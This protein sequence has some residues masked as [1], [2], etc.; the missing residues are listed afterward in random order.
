MV[1]FLLGRVR[2]R[3]PEL[4]GQASADRW[5]NVLIRKGNTELGPLVCAHIDTAHHWT[6]I[7][8]VQHDGPLV[9]FD[10]DGNR[11]GIGADDK[12]GVF[13]C[14]ALLERFENIAVALF[15]QEEIGYIGAQNAVADFFENIGYALEFDCPA[16]GLVSYSA[17]GQRLFQNDGGFIE[18]A[19]P[20]LTRFGFTSFQHHP[21]TDVT[22]LRKRFGFSCLN[23]S[24]GY[25][26]WHSDTE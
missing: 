20:V 17:G 5:N 22:G 14:L 23:V 12:C 7:E 19:L 11:S 3:G 26:G 6:E 15:A 4:C 24:C 25:Y 16:T 1:E 18:A 10:A 2:Q 21:F 9:G 13:I 8:I